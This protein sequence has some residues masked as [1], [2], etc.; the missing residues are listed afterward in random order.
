MKNTLLTVLLFCL[1][2][3]VCMATEK[4]SE[5]RPAPAP[6]PVCWGLDRWQVEGDSV[7]ILRFRILPAPA[8]KGR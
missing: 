4:L 8:G 2:Q 3:L 1:C 7:M 5:V 6:A